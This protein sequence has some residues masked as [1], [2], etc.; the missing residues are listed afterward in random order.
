M[1]SSYLFFQTALLVVATILIFAAGS[2][3]L[4]LLGVVGVGIGLWG[5]HRVKRKGK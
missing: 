1:I 5:A 2:Y 4:G 3:A